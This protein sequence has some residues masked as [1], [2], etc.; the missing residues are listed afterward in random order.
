M[1][2]FGEKIKEWRLAAGLTQKELADKCGI[3]QTTIAS[4]ERLKA[5][6][7]ITK[8]NKIRA[9]LNISNSEFFNFPQGDKEIDILLA[10]LDYYFY[11]ISFPI[12]SLPA[13]EDL[14]AAVFAYIRN[15]IDND[16]DFVIVGKGKRVSVKASALIS[17]SKNASNFFEYE[18]E[19]LL[20]Q[21]G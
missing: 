10:F 15:V 1:A 5:E 7:S 12:N 3:A 17:I 18:L 13:Y 16:E 11:E 2:E 9:A 4:Y 14:D 8:L 6:P 21:N 19:K 20:N